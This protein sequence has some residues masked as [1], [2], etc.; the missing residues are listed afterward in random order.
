MDLDA[1]QHNTLWNLAVTRKHVHQSFLSTA[2]Y[3]SP[4]V[5][6]IRWS[7]YMAALPVLMCT[8]AQ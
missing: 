4:R 8:N 3:Q 7:L 1:D 2:S 6:R 5:W